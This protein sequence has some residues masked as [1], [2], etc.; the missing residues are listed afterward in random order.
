MLSDWSLLF[1]VIPADARNPGKIGS[2][3]HSE[4]SSGTRDWTLAFAGVTIGNTLYS[5]QTL[6]TGTTAFA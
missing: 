1:I 6:Y 2:R 5:W 4:Q 3:L